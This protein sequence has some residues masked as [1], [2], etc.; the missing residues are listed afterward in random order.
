M[1]PKTVHR[2]GQRLRVEDAQEE[3]EAGLAGFERHAS[4]KI[5]EK[6][7]GTAKEILRVNPEIEKAKEAEAKKKQYN[8]DLLAVAKQAIKEDAEKKPKK[9]VKKKAEK[10]EA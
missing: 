10:V 6:E 5:N 4:K 2:D 9:A 3:Y 1:Y 7:K 8:A